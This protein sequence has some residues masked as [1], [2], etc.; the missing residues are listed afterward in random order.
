MDRVSRTRGEIEAVLA[1]S[2]YEVPSVA[3]GGT[4]GLDWLRSTVC[5]F[6]NGDTHAR[7]RRL[8]EDELARMDP[9]SLRGDARRRAARV[10]A[11]S[12]NPDVMSLAR[13]VPLASLGA[14]LGMPDEVLGCAVDDA[15]AVGPAYLTGAGTPEIDAAVDRLASSL[16]RADAERTAAAIAVLA[17]ACEAGAALIG[18]A[19]SMTLD[20]PDLATD[21]DALVDETLRVATPLRAMRRLAPEGDIVVLDLEAASAEGATE[22]P[23]MAFGSGI[24]PCPGRAEAIALACGVLE[25]VV[26]AGVRVV[27]PVSFTE[28]PLRLLGR[29]E[30]RTG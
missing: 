22:R 10:I 29:I 3:A 13:R 20:R 24:R 17:Q 11:A 15:L 14:A 23:T 5:R 26:S 8:V 4:S 28:G 19:L 12:G 6:V 27:G 7:R 30:V 2:A 21:V 9:A 16:A 18:G 1:D 25:A